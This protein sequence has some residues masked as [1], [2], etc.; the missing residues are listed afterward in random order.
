MSSRVPISTEE[1]ERRVKISRPTWER[2]QEDIKAQI[3]AGPA[4][5]WVGEPKNSTVKSGELHILFEITGPWST[6]PFAIPVL[7]RDP[8]GNVFQSIDAKPNGNLSDYVVSLPGKLD[9][10]TLSWVEVRYPGN[11]KRLIPKHG[12]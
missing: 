4:A 5:E 1:L 10:S 7:V 11:T 2:Y 12:Q 3:G 6:R 9:P 8:A